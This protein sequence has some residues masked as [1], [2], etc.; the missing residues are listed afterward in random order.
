MEARMLIGGKLAESSNGTTFPNENPA[1]EEILGETPDA[2]LQDL[3][4]AIAAARRAFDETDW[5]TNHAVRRRCLVQLQQGLE[6]HKEE[7]RHTLIAEAGVPL[8]LTH[9]IQMEDPI[10]EMSFAIDLAAS[11]DYE[12]DLGQAVSTGLPSRGRLLREA[13]GV[14]AAIT[15]FNFPL[16]V[17]LGKVVPALAAGCT[18]VHKPAQQTPWT[19]ALL[20]RIVAEE[21]D[22]LPGVF[23]VITG[24]SDDLGAALVADPRV[25]AIGFTG[26][27]A[28]GRAILRSAAEH[29][30]RVRLELGGKSAAVVLDDADLGLAIGFLSSMACAHS[31]QACAR[32]TRML[33][34]RH[35]YDEGVALATG[36]FAALT[37]GDPNDPGTLHGPQIS[38]EQRDLVLSQIDHAVSEGA[39]LAAGGGK[40]A[41][42]DRGYW[43]EPTLLTDVA[44]DSKTA[45]EEIFGPV[46]AVIPYDDEDDAVRIA[47]HSAY[48]LSGGVWTSDEDRGLALA[49]RLR[50]GTVSINTSMFV[51][52]SWPFGG[53]K[54]SGLG[55]EGGREGFESWLESKV[56]SL[57]GG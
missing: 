48:G 12:R 52:A 57:P 20:G 35:R 41:G 51:H 24:A 21:T 5:A 43:V 36:I 32:H 38:R 14:V 16:F 10:R 4:A 53:Y 39:T 3:D 6:R 19:S 13:V 27:T 33:L 1:T 28:T 42:F 8:A 2:S 15:P 40:P 47:N 17:T 37:C 23:N 34:P 45:Q 7:L 44:A 31:G 18:V 56:V 25:D 54:Q 9:V 11:Y 26:S 29:V 46:L 22:I 55:R 30:K 50:A 49:R